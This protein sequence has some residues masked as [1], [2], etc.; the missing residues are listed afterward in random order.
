MIVITRE[1]VDI[2]KETYENKDIEM[3]VYDNYTLWL[4]EQ[5]IEDKLGHKTVPVITNKYHPVHKKHR[6]EIVEQQRFLCND[7]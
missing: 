4:K 2:T 1:K 7:L 5:H 3:I 6:Y